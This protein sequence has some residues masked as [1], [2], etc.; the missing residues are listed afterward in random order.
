LNGPA[1]FSLE[2]A[3]ARPAALATF[4]QPARWTP[5]AAVPG[6]VVFDRSPRSGQIWQAEEMEVDGQTRRYYGF[7][8]R[9]FVERVPAEEIEFVEPAAKKP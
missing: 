2:A 5:P 3:S 8:G 1:I 6:A 4:P 9:Q 7:V